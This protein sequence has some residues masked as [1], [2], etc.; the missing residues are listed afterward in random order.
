VKLGRHYWNVALS[1]AA[2][3]I[4]RWPLKH[5]FRTFSNVEVDYMAITPIKN[6]AEIQSLFVNAAPAISL[7]PG[8]QIDV[9]A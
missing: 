1:L 7:E 5:R 4:Q 8:G 6:A 2:H 9:K 3:P